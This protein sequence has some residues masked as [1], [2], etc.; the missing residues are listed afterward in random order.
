MKIKKFNNFNLMKENILDDEDD[1]NENKWEVRVDGETK[2]LWEYKHDAIEDGILEILD[3]E[4]DENGLEGYEDPEEEYEMSKSEIADMLYDMD[5]EDFYAKLEEL[6]EYVGY[7]SDIKL[8]NIADEDEID[9][10]E[11]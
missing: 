4:G 9:F 6:K 5:E 2:S 7:D 1:F 3:T 11:D 10:L 8:V